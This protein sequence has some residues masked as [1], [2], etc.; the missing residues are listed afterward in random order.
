MHQQNNAVTSPTRWKH[1]NNKSKPV[2]VTGSDNVNAILD[3]A[4]PKV[5]TEGG[6]LAVDMIVQTANNSK[7]C[8]VY[9]QLQLSN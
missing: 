6:V 2:P 8:L 3:G 1:S 9:K 5:Y 4:N 7:F